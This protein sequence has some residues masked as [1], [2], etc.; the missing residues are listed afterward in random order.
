MPNKDQTLE[1]QLK[2]LFIPIAFPAGKIIS[3]AEY[4]GVEIHEM[5]TG[6]FVFKLGRIWKEVAALVE[7]TAAINKYIQNAST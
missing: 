4:K 7:V 2:E 3:T 6:K 1:D 5:S